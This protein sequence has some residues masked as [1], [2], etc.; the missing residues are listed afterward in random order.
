MLLP[1]VSIGIPTFNQ[2]NYISEA[3]ESALSQ[4]YPNLEVVVADDI[5]TDS[6]ANI[7]S[8]YLNDPRF[9]YFKN[10]YNLGRVGNY[11]TLLYEYAQGDWYVNLDGDDFL[12]DKSFIATGIECISRNKDVVLF[13]ATQFKEDNAGNKIRKSFPSTHLLT[14]V[15]GKDFLLNYPEK[16]GVQHLAALYNRKKAIEIDFY[17][18]NSLRSDSESILRLALKGQVAFYNKPVGVWRD[19]GV[20]ETWLLNEQTLSKEK[21]VFDAVAKEASGV[22][23]TGKLKKWV[24]KVK[25]NIDLYYM[26]SCMAQKPLFS[27]FKF[28][29]GHFQLRLSYLRLF[30]KHLY[31][32]LRFTK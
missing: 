3:I 9:K 6:T 20:N 5:S 31:N 10:S 26:D 24:K 13:Q 19:H 7:A 27:N 23:E 22:I 29:A 14:I 15:E 11:K 12:V 25:E 21:A 16:M 2:E 30:F 4:D 8:R 28:F 1:L 17:R 18:S 32:S